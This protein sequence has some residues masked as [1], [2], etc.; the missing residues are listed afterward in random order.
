MYPS[1][2]IMPPNFVLFHKI[3]H[4]CSVKPVVSTLLTLTFSIFDCGSILDFVQFGILS[5]SGFCP[6]RNFAQFGI[7]SNSAFC[8]IRDFAQF[9]ILSIRDF[10]QF[11]ILSIRDFV[12]TGFIRF[13]IL[14]R[15]HWFLVV[16]FVVP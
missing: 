12:R 15:F 14:Y 2:C 16:L 10:V 3:N 1:K 4:F 5:N 9:G 8:P 6:I 11:G 13:G 7:L